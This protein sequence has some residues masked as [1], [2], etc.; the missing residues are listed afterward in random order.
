MTL[1]SIINR[2][3]GQSSSASAE[4][5]S[6]VFALADEYRR[7][8]PPLPRTV[9]EP[10]GRDGAFRHTERHLQCVWFDPGL[11]PAVLTTAAGETVDVESPGRWNL[12]A[13]PDFLD[14]SLLV[15]PNLR[16]VRGDVEI[17]VRPSD[18][19]SHGHAYDERY[20]RVV[21][22]V[23]YHGG[24][25]PD[26]SL[27]PG[28]L[29]IA[30]EPL[31]AQDPR[32]SFDG[33]DVTAYPFSAREPGSALAARIAGWSPDQIE[34]L[35]DAAGAERLRR[36]VR[37]L[38]ACID[39]L[40]REQ[41]LYEEVMGA[42]GYKQ[43]AAAFRR[44]ARLVPV[45]DLRRVALGDAEVAHA[46]LLGVGGL[47]PA[48]TS[49]RWDDETRLH[50][51][52]LWDLWWKHAAAWEDRVMARKDWTLSQLRPQNHPTR[53]LVAA[54][55]LFSARVPLTQR[56]DS[57]MRND[58]QEWLRVARELFR[59]PSPV[60]YWNRRLSL[61]GKPG[62]TDIAFIGAGRLAAIISNVLVPYA[63]LRKPQFVETR[64]LPV[65]PP[66][67]D[68]GLIREAA[69]QLLGP[70]HNPAMYRSGLRQQ[71]L[72]QIYF[73]FCVPG[74]ETPVPEATAG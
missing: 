50:V 3:S 12:E 31:L 35:L 57:A 26:Y 41:A 67:T 72:L 55:G 6:H 21:A 18:W 44:L 28:A 70:D 11:R 8:L 7:L 40:G 38:N 15:R 45:E 20:R 22:H 69:H 53:R 5:T 10:H 59:A 66:E 19:N 23:T 16:R 60:A 54:A 51:R 13:G 34:A 63:A 56:L 4:E 9:H 36:K 27:P 49:A 33:I 73:D 47:L 65:L 64:L 52:R 62:A 1:R 68:N 30:L 42:L 2:C 25:L 17:H 39:H 46:I 32:F 74:E 61:A 29:Q 37:R 43:N 24:V 71:G 58:P 14:A 48:S